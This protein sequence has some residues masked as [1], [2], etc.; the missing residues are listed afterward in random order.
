[1]I[2]KTTKLAGVYVVEAEPNR[3][4][5]GF[6]A[7]TFCAKEFEQQGLATQFVQCSVSASQWRGTLRGLHYQRSPHCEAK[8]LR[9]T[10]GAVFEVVVDLRRESVTYRQH[11]GVEL[12]AQTHRAVY[13]PE[14]CANGLQTLVDESEVFYQ[15][16][17][18][19]APES[20]AGLRFDDPKL[21]IQWPLPVSHLSDKDKNWPPLD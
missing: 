14:M 21:A 5:R 1:M 2:F 7:R 10:K 4:T 16:S 11:I 8:L 19:Y 9:C 13:I 15:I 18:Y 12:S 17:E 6:F 20:A 3:D